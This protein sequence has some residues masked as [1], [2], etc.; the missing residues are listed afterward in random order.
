[1]VDP[2]FH[3]R[4]HCG[5]LL[6]VTG[7]VASKTSSAWIEKSQQAV[8]WRMAAEGTA[9]WF[10]ALARQSLLRMPSINYFTALK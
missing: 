4:R 7:T 8:L 10:V 1:M 2:P 5:S 3:A 6:L 9:L